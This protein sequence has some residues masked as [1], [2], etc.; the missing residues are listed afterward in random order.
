MYIVHAKVLS[1]QRHYRPNGACKVVICSCLS[2]VI[3]L[4]RSHLRGGR[5]LHLRLALLH[6]SLLGSDHVCEIISICLS[7]FQT[8][9]QLTHPLILAWIPLMMHPLLN[10]PLMR[11]IIRI[12]HLDRL[13]P[14]LL[15]PR[16]IRLHRQT[17]QQNRQRQ[18]LR[19]HSCLHQLLRARQVRVPV[20]ERE[21]DA[22]GGHP[23]PEDDA[24][25]VLVAPVLRALPE[26]LVLI[27]LGA[28][29][30]LRVGGLFFLWVAL[31]VEAAG[32]AVGGD[33]R[34]T[35]IRDCCVINGWRKA[36]QRMCLLSMRG[37]FGMVL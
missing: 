24:V 23:R 4:G 35:R 3:A 11:R 20:H 13:P 16:I 1:H 10:H 29:L 32:G 5:S 27:Y 12:Q 18:S 37:M 7:T 26:G 31:G 33:D 8:M 9:H 6:S 25:S 21:R 34:C 15:L 17:R 19:I 2:L 22:H 14:P 28:E 30:G 36:Y